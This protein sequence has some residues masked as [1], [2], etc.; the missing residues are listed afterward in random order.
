MKWEPL[1]SFLTQ[2]TT[3]SPIWMTEEPSHHLHKHGESLY[4]FFYVIFSVVQL[5]WVVVPSV[6]DE[7]TLELNNQ[8]ND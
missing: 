1:S 7:K 4:F 2:N 5:G 8:K 6:L 3:H